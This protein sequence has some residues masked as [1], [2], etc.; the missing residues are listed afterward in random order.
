MVPILLLPARHKNCLYNI[1]FL[2]ILYPF[3]FFGGGG[4]LVVVVLIL[5]ISSGIPGAYGAPLACSLRRPARTQHSF[6]V[7]HGQLAPLEP[8]LTST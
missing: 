8:T 5:G 4:F 7:R 2:I 3:F 1:A 6:I